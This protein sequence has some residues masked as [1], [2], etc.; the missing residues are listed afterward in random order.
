M[1]IVEL[2][3]LALSGVAIGAFSAIFGVGGGTLIVPLLVF[4]FDQ[5]QH[6]AEGTSLLVIVPTAVVGAVA[7]ARNDYVRARIAV[8]MAIG[9]SAGAA[10]GASLALEL[11]SEMLQNLFG[12]FVIVSGIRVIQQAV[13]KARSSRD[14][15][16]A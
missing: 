15:E 11:S 8:L 9:G 4:G 10:V 3:I 16:A 14:P 12:A 5:G 6:L 1:T 7:H 13:R 2:G